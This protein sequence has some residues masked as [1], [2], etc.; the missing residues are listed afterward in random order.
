MVRAVAALFAGS[1]LIAFPAQAET[2]VPDSENGRYSFNQVAEGLLRLDSRTGQVSLCG[3][4]TVGWSCQT[5]PDERA[6]LESEIGRLQ[7][8]TAALKKELISRGIALP[9]GIKSSDRGADKNDAPVLKLP[10]DAELERVMT[11]F[12]KVW[13]RFVDMVQ[14]MQKDPDKKS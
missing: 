8:E 9:G 14:S 5:V 12:E 2:A 7:N 1:A 3:K 10:S 6:A 13:R 4:R 11:F